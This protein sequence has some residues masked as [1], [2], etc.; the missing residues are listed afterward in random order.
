MEDERQIRSVLLNS[1]LSPCPHALPSFHRPSISDSV[2]RRPV[3]FVWL[4][5]VHEFGLSCFPRT[6]TLLRALTHY[7]AAPGVI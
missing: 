6:R 5:N 3:N 7:S 1:G 4:F 2:G